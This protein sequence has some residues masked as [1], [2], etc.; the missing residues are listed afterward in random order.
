MLACARG[1]DDVVK[2][3]LESGANVESRDKVR[4]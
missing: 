3:L 4:I 2:E 1:N